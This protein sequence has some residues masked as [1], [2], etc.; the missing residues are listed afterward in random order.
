MP[1]DAAGKE[2]KWLIVYQQDLLVHST[3]EAM[4]GLKAWNPPGRRSQR[5]NPEARPE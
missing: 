3:G 4:T 2:N 1:G 5:H